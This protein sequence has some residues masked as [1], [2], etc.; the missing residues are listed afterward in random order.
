M[1]TTT[2]AANGK[3]ASNLAL[4]YSTLA[5]MGKKMEQQQQGK[6]L[7]FP[8]PPDN[9]NV[10]HRSNDIAIVSATASIS[11]KPATVVS[12]DIVAADSETM[13]T[14]SKKFD[15][16]VEQFKYTYTGSSTSTNN[17][18][19]GDEMQSSGEPALVLADNETNLISIFLKHEFVMEF[20]LLID[21]E[22]RSS[23]SFHSYWATPLSLLPICNYSY[24]NEIP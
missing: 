20:K 13:T 7:S 11:Q 17:D 24:A 22:V 5:V 23:S 14:Y 6:D 18:A 21:G 4:I 16:L 2:T 12:T 15:G 9:N 19:G 8:L 3:D 1:S 10:P